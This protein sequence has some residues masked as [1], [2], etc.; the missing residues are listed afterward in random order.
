MVVELELEMEDQ[1][2]A[3]V[4]ND[5]VWFVEEEEEVGCAGEEETCVVEE[6]EVFIP[7]DEDGFV[8]E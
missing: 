8:V 1:V 3:R 2:P 7:E 6:E 4:S 5:V